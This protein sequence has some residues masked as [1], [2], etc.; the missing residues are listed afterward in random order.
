MAAAL[1]D[2]GAVGWAVTSRGASSVPRRSEWPTAGFS[3]VGA[4][5]RAELVA[6]P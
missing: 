5:L 3:S 1:G 6:L 2:A 4:N